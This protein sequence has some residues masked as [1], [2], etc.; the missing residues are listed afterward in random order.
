M[1]LT[2]VVPVCMMELL[3]ATPE[4]VTAPCAA[5]EVVTACCAL[6]VVTVCC[7]LVVIACCALSKIKWHSIII[8]ITK[9]V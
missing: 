3:Y 4:V 9:L 1:R 6:E 2:I 8:I 7:V 5:L